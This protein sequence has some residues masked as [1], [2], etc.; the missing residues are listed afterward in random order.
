M[1]KKSFYSLRC[2]QALVVLI[3]ALTA[4]CSPEENRELEQNLSSTHSFSPS[5]SLADQQRNAGEYQQ[6][7][8]LYDSLVKVSGPEEKVY[9]SINRELC[10]FLASDT[11]S[12]LP[13]GLPEATTVSQKVS[14]SLLQGIAETRNGRSGLK[15]FYHVG[16]LLRSDDKKGTFEYF[17]MLE[18]LAWCHQ[19]VHGETDSSYY[20]YKEALDMAG[21][22]QEL[23]PHIPRLLVQLSEVAITNRDFVAALGYTE[24]GLRQKPRNK[25]LHELLILK[26][27][28]M[29]RME[30]FD[31][32]TYYYQLADE[33]IQLHG[34]TVSLAKLLRERALHE[35]IVNNDSLFRYHMSR[36][37]RLPAR[38][39]NSAVVSTD[40]LYGFYHFLRGNVQA[41]IGAYERAVAHFS[42]QKLA[43][44]V[45]VG[46]ANF[47]LTDLYRSIGEFE[48]AEASIF[49]SLTYF[50][51][52]RGEDVSWDDIIGPEIAGHAFN[53]VNYRQLAEIQLDR[54]KSNISDERS[55]LRSF[56]LYQIIDSLMFQQIRVV[57]EDA[58]LMF[59]RQ[60]SLIYSGGIETSYY[61]Y[62]STGD[63]TFLSQAHLFMERSK[64]LIVYQDLLARNHDYFSDVPESFRDQEL[65]L[66]ARIAALKQS[67]A[68]DSPELAGL[69]RQADQYYQVMEKEYPEY[70]K[71]KYKVS[72]KSYDYFSQLADERQTTIVQYFMNDKHVYFLRY[73]G[74]VQF[75]RLEVDDSFVDALSI[76]T[77]QLQIMPDRKNDVA[78]RAFAVASSQLYLKLIEPL[79][80]LKHNLLIIPD[81]SL[82]HLPFEV[83]APDSSRSYRDADYLVKKHNIHYA[84]SL[85][86][87]QLGNKAYV[88]SFD[89]ILGYSFTRGKFQLS[90]LPGTGKELASI[91][92]VFEGTNLTVRENEQVTREQMLE[93]LELE[94]DLVHIGLH[95]TSSDKDRL[96][97]K[98]QCYSVSGGE[99]AQVYG[100]EIAPL[101]LKAHTVVLTACQSAYGPIVRGEGTYSLARAF[102]Q[103][104]AT[105]V[106]ASLWNLSDA[107]TSQVV[108]Q[109]YLGLKAGKLASESLSMAKRKYIEKADELT[110]HPHF[111]AGLVCT[112]Y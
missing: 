12:I 56:E 34:D 49:N 7:Y 13:T 71:A 23:S 43:D 99:L 22:F 60:G 84:P 44:I 86:V 9:A 108:D 89:K 110:A 62:K 29:R 70:Y 76:L 17:T 21:E 55:L 52:F 26:A 98:I 47:V 14:E 92:R 68:Y 90:S 4:A 24:E 15:N 64:G 63:T 16:A 94:Y 10:R 107:T 91:A 65:Q 8:E 45:Q 25:N 28:L 111:W 66:K 3:F 79:Q 40:R 77:D 53:F 96:E 106:V 6:A 31:S 61:L 105:N 69:L 27:T 67:N 1:I 103:A 88:R 48:K 104:G 37:E 93:D 57:E 11:L 59:L 39:A 41:S 30:K 85:R 54:Y 112:G 82:D 74:F 2:K 5:I 73:G 50:T 32:A 75:E 80:S 38:F 101:Q 58:L 81:G 20:Y 72:S 102:K 35:M 83:L 97:N 42:R 109:F 78:K 19:M 87:Y 18:Q 33:K 51:S 100:F 95:A 46:E 36:L